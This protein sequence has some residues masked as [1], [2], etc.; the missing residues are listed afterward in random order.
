MLGS[1]YSYSVLT[2]TTAQLNESYAFIMSSIKIAV[3]D[4]VAISEV[5]NLTT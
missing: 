1:L 2:N 4:L 3:W 5:T